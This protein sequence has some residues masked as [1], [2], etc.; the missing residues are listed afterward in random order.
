MIGY[1]G[2]EPHRLGSV[3]RRVQQVFPQGVGD[4]RRAAALEGLVPDA[5]K[6]APGLAVRVRRRGELAVA[7]CPEF[8]G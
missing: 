3:G 2:L 8:V 4:V 6:G 7:F 5:D 1:Q